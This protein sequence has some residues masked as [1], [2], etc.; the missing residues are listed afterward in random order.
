MNILTVD[1]SRSIRCMVKNV[2]TGAGHTV[3]E[4]C[5][6][7]EAADLAAG[8]DFDLI[9]TDINM[10]GM[11]GLELARLLRNSDEY[12]S[13]PIIFLTTEAS[14]EF[15]AKGEKIGTTTWITKPFSPVN[16]LDVVMGLS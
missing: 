2:L 4:A 10:P 1:D 13:T 7:E 15:K 12:K 3:V 11:D 5:D 6:G 16:L 14:E 8:S 9:V